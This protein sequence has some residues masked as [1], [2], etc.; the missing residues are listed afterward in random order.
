MKQCELSDN[1]LINQFLSGDQMAIELLI[2]RH[3]KRVFGY[4][5]LLVKNY[6]IAEDVF[7]DTFIKVIKSLQENKYT[8]SGRFVSW[9]MRIAHNLIIDHF[10]REK[11]QKTYSNDQSEIDVF[12]SPK[13]SDKNVEEIMVF[14]QLLSEVRNLV[15][16]LPDEQ[17]EVV[18]L[19]HYSGLSF[20]EIAEQTNVSINTALGRMR[21]ALINMRKIMQEKNL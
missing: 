18:M 10:R 20:K 21:Y 5:L 11:Q 15:D 3:R 12:N 13:F 8:D 9:V 19:R 17:K 6:T 14:E 2:R 7:Q 1:E 4:I 16:E